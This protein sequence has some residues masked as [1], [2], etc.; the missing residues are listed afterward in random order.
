VTPLFSAFRPLGR[1]GLEFEVRGVHVCVVNAVRR[2][3]MADVQTAAFAVDPLEHTDPHRNGV[4]ITTNTTALNNEQVAYRLGLVP[5]DLDEAQLRAF[6]GNRWLFQVQAKNSGPT[7]LKVTSGDIQVRSAPV[8]VTPELRDALFPRNEISGD[9]ILLVPLKPASASDGPGQELSVQM[10]ARLGTGSEH[11]RWSPVCRCFFNYLVD[12]A[13]SEAAFRASQSSTSQAQDR[14]QW[15]RLHAPRHFQKDAHGEPAAFRFVLEST[16]RLSP[17]YLVHA[18]L[19]ALAA[20]VSRMLAA[21]P[22][23]VAR[24][25][26]AATAATRPAALR[27]G[28][29]YGEYDPDKEP[30]QVLLG[31]GSPEMPL[32]SVAVSGED[33]TLGNLVQSMLYNRW[34]RDGGGAVV[35]FI[36][37]RMPH[38]HEN[39]VVFQVQCARDGLSATLS[40]GLAWVRA[41]LLDLAAEWNAAA[42]GGGRQGASN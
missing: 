23:A 17:A 41:S 6:D 8:P 1:R 19:E 7:T 35:P 18:A 12:E 36:G 16:T 11:A 37:Y 40:E 24:A 39:R 27:R 31:T 38:Q 10:V 22:A 29:G 4:V 25:S 26:V 5:L 3:V 13:A 28:G 21:L 33:D 20:K 15:D 34:V 42:A 2:A 9:H 14:Q 30:V 32:H